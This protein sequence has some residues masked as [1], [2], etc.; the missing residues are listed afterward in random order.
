ML[1]GERTEDLLAT[2]DSGSDVYYDLEFCASAAID[3]GVDAFLAVT[4]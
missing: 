3:L 4:A 1:F 2:T